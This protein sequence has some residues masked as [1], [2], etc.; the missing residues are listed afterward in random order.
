MRMKFY[1]NPLFLGA[2]KKNQIHGIV[3]FNDLSS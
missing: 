2:F 3:I 1:K